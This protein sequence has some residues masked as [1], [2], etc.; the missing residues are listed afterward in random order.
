MHSPITLDALR[1]LDAIDRKK[2]FAGAA[3]A[4]FRVPSAIS[5]TVNKLEEELGVTLYDRSKRKAELTDIGRM[6]LVQGRLILTATETLTNAARQSASGW[7]VELRIAVDSML[8]FHP[9]YELIE[10]FQKEHPWIAIKVVEEV[11]GGTWDALTTDRCDLVIGAPG[12]T[13]D[14]SI[15][16]SPIGTLEL[17]F[18]VAQNH[19]LCNEPQPLSQ[20]VI[21]N[22]PALVVADS[23]RT[24]QT[25][26]AG[27]LDGQPRITVPSISK[28][29]EAQL[30]G[31]GVG[32]L[33]V[34]RIQQQLQLGQLVALEV[35]QTD[36]RE[37][38]I[39]LA[40]NK[41]NQGKALAWFVEKIQQF[42]SGRF[43]S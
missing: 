26:S 10:A 30:Q 19:A 22:Y 31:L 8:N 27:L 42:E 28:K 13:N 37:G 36:K 17:V 29:I 11:F 7:E 23:S 43:L 38:D 5:Y 2:S 33:P 40:W 14:T 39:H 24:L 32:Y 16:T 1:V 15:A 34:H 20:Q 4:L 25:R 41:N 18:A 3:E 9:L 21:K 35:Q 12:S 6:I